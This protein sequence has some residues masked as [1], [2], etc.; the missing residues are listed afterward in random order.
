MLSRYPTVTLGAMRRYSAVR[1][2]CVSMP[3]PGPPSKAFHDA[4]RWLYVQRLGVARPTRW[5][6]VAELPAPLSPQGRRDTASGALRR[7]ARL[8]SESRGRL[9]VPKRVWPPELGLKPA[10]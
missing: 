2:R 10:R 9:A 8:S 5:G 6:G 3:R 4:S 7:I 1:S